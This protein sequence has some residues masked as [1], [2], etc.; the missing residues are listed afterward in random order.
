MSDNLLETAMKM[1]KPENYGYATGGDG[2][3]DKT[4]DKIK[5]IDCSGLVSSVLRA[6]G[7][8]MPFPNKY[9]FD[10]NWLRS[11]AAE[12]YFDVIEKENVQPGDIVVWAPP[13][14]H[15]YG[16]TGLVINYDSATNK[17]TLYGSN[18]STDGPGII[19][20]PKDRLK[21]DSEK[22]GAKFLRPKT[23]YRQNY[24]P[25][26]FS[27]AQKEPVQLACAFGDEPQLDDDKDYYSSP[28]MG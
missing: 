10:T 16:H 28:G 23:E 27:E 4:G 2:T 19:S 7:Y 13:P 6:A 22:G 11:K 17:G 8:S 26:P 12:T 3:T 1:Y 14:G 21:L 18:K 5:D 9:R 20:I 25:G 24:V 15:T